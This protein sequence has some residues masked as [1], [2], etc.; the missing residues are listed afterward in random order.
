MPP[1]NILPDA[2]Q[3]LCDGRDESSAPLPLWIQRGEFSYSTM[4]T[5][6][7][8][9][10]GQTWQRYNEWLVCRSIPSKSPMPLF[11]PGETCNLSKLNG[12]V[13][14]SGLIFADVNRAED[15]NVPKAGCIIPSP[16]S[17][18]WSLSK[19]RARWAHQCP[20][21]QNTRTVN[22]DVHGG[23]NALHIESVIYMKT[24]LGG[25][26]WYFRTFS[27]SNLLQFQYS[28]N[29]SRIRL[30][31]QKQKLQ[32]VRAACHISR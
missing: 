22:M 8:F 9:S 3:V 15:R 27:K 16:M 24:M 1:E 5:F 4:G 19:L 30:Q 20:T 29:L 17:C 11:L 26:C 13:V 18:P 21:W 12:P 23:R 10:L 32:Q 25:K 6:E 2:S 28:Y 31:P 7:Y 14:A